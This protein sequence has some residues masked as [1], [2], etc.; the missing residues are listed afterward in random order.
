MFNPFKK[1]EAGNN[2]P[3]EEITNTNE[4]EASNEQEISP[5]RI[6][7]LKGLDNEIQEIAGLTENDLKESISDP[8]EKKV[9]G[10]KVNTLAKI[11]ETFKTHSPEIAAALVGLSALAYSLINTTPDAANSAINQAPV[12]IADA[13]TAVSMLLAGGLYSYKS[14]WKEKAQTQTAENSA[15]DSIDNSGAIAA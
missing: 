8:E 10:E 2:N 7:A 15:D 5:E 11:A 13:I 6:E 14:F 1:H 4:V 12:V 9:L 3:V